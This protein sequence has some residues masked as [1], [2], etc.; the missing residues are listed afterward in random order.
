VIYPIRILNLTWNRNCNALLRIKN[1]IVT[2][3]IVHDS[4]VTDELLHGE[5]LAIYGD[6]AFTRAEKKTEYGARGIE[7]CINWRANRGQ[8]LTQ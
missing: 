1:I 3:A 2:N 8:Q 4:R 7:W 5:E 6:N